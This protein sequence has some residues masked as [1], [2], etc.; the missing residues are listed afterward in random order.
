MRKYTIAL[1]AM[2]GDLGPHISLLAAKKTLQE[3]PTLSLI[4]V[5]TREKI[6]P[7]LKQYTLLDHSR[8]SFIHADNIISMEDNP[9]YVLRHVSNSSMHVALK[10]VADGKADACVS[11]GNTGAL[12]L[13][14]KQALKTIPGI[15]RPA[16]VSGLPN[17]CAGY[18]YLL[19]LGANLQCDSDTLFNFAVMGSVLCENVEQ[20]EKPKVAL[21]NVG[22]ENNKG[23]DIIKRS[24]SL[25]NES[26]H[27]NYVGFIEANELF[28]SK[29]DVVVTDGFSGNIAL[30][31]YEGMGRV[32][33]QQLDKAVNSNFYSKLLGKLLSPILKKQFKHL[34]PDMY[35]GASLIGLRGIVVKS[36]GSANQVAFGYAIEQAIKEIQWQIPNSISNRLE[37]VLLERD[38]LSH[39]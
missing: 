32:F 35:N 14:A 12:M 27:I 20:L 38:C 10:I 1:D 6:I 13:L 28:S 5:G 25:L 17:N 39:E 29:A 2:G 22:K 19:D 4:I 21:L 34:H 15:S 16:L 33:L 31:S 8:L 26:K 3:Y 9:V 18:T 7:L 23:S 11:A 30:K 24:A 37:A 36:H